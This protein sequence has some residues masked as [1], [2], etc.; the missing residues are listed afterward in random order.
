MGPGLSELAMI[1]ELLLKLAALNQAETV[2]AA[3]F[4]SSGTSTYCDPLKLAPGSAVVK[5]S[6]PFTTVPA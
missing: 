6:G 5:V 1:L 2:R 4:T 3:E